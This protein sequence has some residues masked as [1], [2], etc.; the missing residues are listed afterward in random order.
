MRD[1]HVEVRRWGSG[2]STMYMYQYRHTVLA[3]SPKS[4]LDPSS[5]TCKSSGAISLESRSAAK[6]KAQSGETKL[7]LW[8]ALIIYLYAFIK[9]WKLF[10]QNQ[11]HWNAPVRITAPPG[12]RWSTSTRCN[13]IWFH[14]LLPILSSTKYAWQS[15]ETHLLHKAG[16][17]TRFC[18]STYKG[19]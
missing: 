5:K 13:N 11:L 9:P 12:T 1:K 4:I 17:S 19:K 8:T 18:L 6:F 14:L 10:R 16:M 3:Q 7:N 2:L 15:S